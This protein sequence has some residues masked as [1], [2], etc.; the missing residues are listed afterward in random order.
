MAD[1]WLRVPKTTD[2]DGA[3]TPKYADELE[4]WSGQTLAESPRYLIRCYGTDSTL[5]SIEAN[6]DVQ[7][8]TD[9][10]VSDA[11]NSLLDAGRDIDGWERA[12]KV[13]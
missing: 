5:D 4:G 13:A 9:A 1:R 6:D 12:F 2:D 11:L 7:S 3:T 8:P 10:E